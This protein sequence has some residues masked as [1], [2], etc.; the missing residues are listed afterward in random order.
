[1]TL[2][3]IFSNEELRRAEF[4]VAC[5]SVFLAHAGVAPLPRR[6]A[7]AVRTYALQC[8][9][10]DQESVGPILQ[11]RRTRELAARVLNATPEEISFVGPTTLALSFIAAGLAFKR[12]DNVLV[13]Q[14]DY[15]S[16]V[17]PWMALADRGVEVRFM[18]IR[19]LGCIQSRDVIGQVNEQTRLVA[20]ASCHFVSGFRIDLD[21]IGRALRQ[22]N[23]LFCVDAIQ[24]VGA[25]PTTVEQIDFLAADSHKWMLGPCAAGILFVRK[26]LR[27][28][29]QPVAVGWSN[30]RCPDF[31]AQD[32]LV[33]RTN[34]RRFEAGTMNLLGLAGLHAALELL[35]EVGIDSIA[36][37]L[38]RKRTWLVPALEAKGYTVLQSAPPP[39]N[40][41]AIVSFY[42]DGTAMDALHASLASAGIVT[43]IRAD[44]SGRKYIR[45]SPHFYNTDA[46]LE[47]CLEKL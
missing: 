12:G 41:S 47:R 38:V 3:E 22:R 39:E 36:Q 46:E 11:L 31:V 7:E 21:A 45:L 33:Y 2:A 42:R 26:E 19:E 8:T 16:N 4:P 17:Y 29:M 40:Q 18:N 13:Y 15:P 43:S 14:D 37:E 24:T 23:I 25:F 1:M 10:G 32:E 20:L 34:G 44:R 5:R 9:L 30:V 6:V 27:E 28:K 35:L